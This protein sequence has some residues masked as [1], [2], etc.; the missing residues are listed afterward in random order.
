MSEDAAAATEHPTAEAGGATA[1]ATASHGAGTGA[2][3]QRPDPLP[4]LKTG[5]SNTDW[6]KYLQQMLNYHY[7]SQVVMEDGDYD[8]QTAG[9]VEHFR[10]QQGLEG[11]QTVDS[12]VW[13]KLGVED[14]LEQWKR[15]HPQGAGG[16]SGAPPGGQHGHDQHGA[17]HG[18]QGHGQGQHGAG[19]HGQGQEA[20]QSYEP[21][22]HNV[23]F[24]APPSDGSCW[25]AAMAMVLNAK[26]LGS[27]TPQ[28]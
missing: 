3:E 17:Q 10:S 18:Q 21:V 9:A 5:T 15:A 16:G 26:A 27:F 11:G 2:S 7:G 22:Y 28:A 1:T 12:K 25:A 4:T 23:D 14:P 6:V 8:G 20:E 13:E 19:G 24:I